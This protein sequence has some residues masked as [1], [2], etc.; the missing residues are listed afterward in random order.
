MPRT[1]VNKTEVI[2][3]EEPLLKWVNNGGPF[4]RKNGTKVPRG[5]TF[6]AAVDEVPVAFRDN[7][8][9][10][11]PAAAAAILSKPLNV[12]KPSFRLKRRGDTFFYDVLDGSGKR[13]NEKDLTEAEA[14]AVLDKLV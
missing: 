7:I 11:D 4:Y 2:I 3:N 14:K 8:K 9:P 13:I 12:V 10:I 6:E 1:K 5:G